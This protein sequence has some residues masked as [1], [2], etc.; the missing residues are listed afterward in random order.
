MPVLFLLSGP[1]MG[2]NGVSHKSHK[3]SVDPSGEAADRI[4]KVRG[5][6]MGWTSSITTPSM[7]VIVGRALAVDEKV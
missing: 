3:F 4:K 6:K 2:K 5:A 7:V 1:K